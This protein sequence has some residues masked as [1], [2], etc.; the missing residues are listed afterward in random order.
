MDVENQIIEVKINNF[1]EKH[2]LSIGY[3]VKNG[4]TIKVKAKDLPYGSGIKVYVECEF[5]HK[6]FLKAWRRYLETKECVC[7]SDCKKYKMMNT[8]IK[9]YGNKCSLKNPY[10]LE[11]S[12]NTIM[13]KYGVEYPLQSQHIQKR[14]RETYYSRYGNKSFSTSISKTQN[15]LCEIYNGKLNVYID[16]YFVDI[17]VDNIV[18]E[19]DGSGHDLSVRLGK[20]SQ[21]DFD[22]NEIYR[23]N[24]LIQNGYKILRILY[25]N[26]QDTL[27]EK[28][29][30]YLIFDKAKNLFNNGYNVVKYNLM[31][32]LLTF[33]F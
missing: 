1:N 23:E 29:K 4:D 17:L 7:C 31:N 27:P 2:F 21:Q 22:E 18:V 8:D 25:M 30:L 5:C 10:I 9:K 15:E 28:E 32:D 14:A 24:I 16:G 33:R 26:K 3:D 19:Y 20:V 11:K 12:K 13:E 6:I